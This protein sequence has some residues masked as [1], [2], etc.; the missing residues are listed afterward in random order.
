MTK[1]I[2]VGVIGAGHWGPNLIRNFCDNQD[3]ELAAVCDRDPGRCELIRSRYRDVR[4][5]QDAA[6][7]LRDDT[8]DAVVVATPA[9]THF[10]LCR[11]ALQRGKHVLVEKPITTNSAEAAELVA[12]AAEQK[13]VLMVGHVFLYNLA[14]REVKKI[15]SNG[16]FGRSY[17]F[18]ARRLSLG[19]VREDVH[20][21]WDLATHDISIFLYL[22]GAVPV[23]VTANGQSF[24]RDGIPDVI[25]ATLYFEDGTV[26]GLHTSWLDPQKIR[27]LTVVGEHGMIVF[28]DMNLAEPVRIYQKSF[29]RLS[30]NASGSL[31]DTLGQFRVQL[32]QGNVVI[33]NV[34][35][36]EPLRTECQAFINAIKT[37]QLPESDGTFGLEVVRVLEA[38]DRSMRA[39]ARR[40]PVAQS[41]DPIAAH[42]P[43]QRTAVAAG[44]FAAGFGG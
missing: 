9:S 11:T 20:A 21:G 41:S 24:I 34:T 35:T 27:Q 32:N 42:I 14:V 39:G 43:D 30:A 6:E 12:L 23:E 31:I 15:I 10:P 2:R 38:I 29:Q 36:G 19:P 44:Q 16:D 25:F 22:K 1:P 40:V 37:G 33:P 26:A 18:H 17:Y 3:T 5:V 4:V 28:D 7:V 13:R 8:V